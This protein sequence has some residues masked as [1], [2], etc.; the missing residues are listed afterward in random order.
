MISTE[1]AGQPRGGRRPQPCLS[2]RVERGGI[3]ARRSHAERER[4]PPLV[5]GREPHVDGQRGLVGVLHPRLRRT[6]RRRCPARAPGHPLLGG[7][8]GVQVA[9]RRPEVGERAG[10]AG[11]VPHGRRDPA[12]RPGRPAHL[13]QPRDRVG[14]EVHDELGHGHVDRVVLDRQCSAAPTRA[15]TPGHRRRTTSRNW[16]IGS[17]AVT[18]ASPRT[19]TSRPVRAP[20]PQPTSRAVCPSSRA[21]VCHE[22]VGQG[23][24]EAAHEPGVGVGR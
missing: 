10:V 13:P 22:Q 6:A 12:T 20:G 1:A 3:G 14:H 2:L 9:G 23:L 16:S 24:G 8:L 18:A 17:T 19:S 4:L 5:E 11:Q 21:E 15:R 7:H